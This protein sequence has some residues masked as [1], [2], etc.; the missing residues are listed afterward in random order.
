[1]VEIAWKRKRPIVDVH[2][3]SLLVEHHGQ[4]D[5]IVPGKHRLTAFGAKTH[6]ELWQYGEGEGP[7]HG[8]I[9]AMPVCGDGVVYLQLWR[10]RKIHAMRLKGRWK[11]T[12]SG[13]GEQEAGA[14]GT[15]AGILL[16]PPLRHL[17]E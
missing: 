9:I 15:V 14:L 2:A 16:W 7:W 5:I 3:T 11:T 10:E 4:T 1:M 13:V 17:G 6:N 12:R 8:E